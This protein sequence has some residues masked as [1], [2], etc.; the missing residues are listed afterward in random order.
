MG[1]GVP[2]L[3]PVVGNAAWLREAGK[4]HQELRGLAL[5]FP[6]VFSSPLSRG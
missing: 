2:W 3:F 4:E 6:F 1:A 5:S